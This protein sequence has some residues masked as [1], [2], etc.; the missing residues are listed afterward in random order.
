MEFLSFPI[1]S[2]DYRHAGAA[3]RAIKEYLKRIGA[4]GEAVRRTMIAAYEAEMNVVI[5]SVG[6]RLEASLSDGQVDVTVVD[7]G[8]GIPD[9][10]LAMT[11]GF[12]TAT[13]EARALGF[14]AGMG[15]PNIQRNS[16][17]LRITSAPGEGTRLS[18][19]VSLREGAACSPSALS[20]NASAGKCR[21][22]RACVAI[23][24]TGAMRLRDDRPSVLDHLCIDCAD[25]IGSC[26]A[27]A[28]GIRDEIY[29]LSEV[30]D[31]ESL[32]LAVPP[33][34]L[35][36][37]G[38]DHTPAQV[39]D[40]LGRLGFSD[41]VHVGPFETALRAAVVALA[42]E[43]GPKEKPLI[44][45]SCPA[46]V[47]LIEL[48]FPS[49]LPFLA[50]YESPWAALRRTSGLRPAAF[51]VSCPSQ[52]S[53]LRSA[54]ETTA[55]VACQFGRA[56]YLTPSLV[57]QEVMV[58]LAK[59]VA[60]TISVGSGRRDPPAAPKP[61]EAEDGVLMVTG[62]SGV[63]A[64]LEQLENGLLTDVA[65]IE[66]YACK[67]G[68]F[69]SPLLSEDHH[70]STWRWNRGQGEVPAASELK[71]AAVPRT[72]PFVARPGIRLDSEMARAIEKL[73]RLQKLIRSLPGKD[74]GSCGAPSCAAL[75]EDIVMERAG[76]ELCPYAGGEVKEPGR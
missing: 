4:D 34:L 75:A 64:V 8:P 22:C 42:A 55:A 66:P 28:L 33:S 46:V 3:S 27:E 40:A 73:G 16:D 35:A 20:L 32:V 10:E 18:F 19:T 53:A 61:A 52:R 30:V 54:E 45:P 41:V 15:L 59:H 21:Q 26:S 36:G 13:S 9:I 65:V 24:P 74:C 14:G 7:D 70:V 51:V 50:P 25:C 2:Q 62:L 1:V 11:E 39:F 57:R 23:C 43:Q 60:T 5:H 6:G 68:C 31:K 38:P 29:S 58:E 47:N 56:E 44:A 12:S 49:L 48:R 71:A 17:L 63:T 37:C 76:I 69:G 72:V 67:G